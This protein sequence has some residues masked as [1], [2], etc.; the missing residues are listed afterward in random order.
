MTGNRLLVNLSP[1]HR[2][3]NH[4]H[5]GYVK[6]ELLDRSMG[7]Y[8]KDHIDGFGQDDSDRLRADGYEQVVSWNGNSDLS[9]LKGKKVYIRFWLKSAYL[10]GFQ[11]AD[12]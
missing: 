2:A 12:E 3:W 7:P 11:F 4:Q 6:V 9:A 8:N 1:E 5:H 10:F